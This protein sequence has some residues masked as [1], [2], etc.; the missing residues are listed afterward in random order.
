MYRQEEP[1][2]NL[3][4]FLERIR[5]FFR[6][7]PGGGGL[8][9]MAVVAGFVIAFGIWMYSGLYTVDPG[10]QAAL[11]MLGKFDS[12]TEPGLHW[13]WPS[14]IGTRDVVNV[15]EVRRLEV[16][17]RGG[18]PVDAEALM[19][20]GDENIVNAQLVVQY[21][22]QQ[23]ILTEDGGFVL[24]I[25]AFLFRSSDPE[26]TI[27]KSATE[28]A[29]R[30]A[31]GER[32]IDDV[33]TELKDEVQQETKTLLQV[34]LDSYETGIRIRE[35]KLQNV[36][37]P[38]QVQD[39]FD[40]VVRAKENRETIINLAEAYEAQ[41][42]PTA[43]GQATR[44][45]QAAQAFKAERIAKAT[46]EAAR[47]LDVLRAFQESQ[48]VTRQRL[49]LEAMEEILPGVTKFIVSDQAGG[50][51]LQFLPIGAS[52]SPSPLEQV[53]QQP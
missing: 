34:L 30:Q 47:F 50:N 1:D 45:I 26:G 43:K 25:E 12:V 53:A 8:V 3:G 6:R 15:L 16:G 18:T 29:L 21:D 39:A 17:L 13:F 37:A 33:L 46:G 52:A 48:D 51:L 22:I 27:L 38:V 44:T 32:D 5:N 40:D 10:E 4:Q 2:I 7:L 36:L 31:V 14:P 19:I 49:Y 41:V 42:L 23:S 28:S 35:V 11:R 24:P 20:T 9:P